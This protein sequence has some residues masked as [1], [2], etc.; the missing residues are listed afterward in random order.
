MIRCEILQGVSVELRH[1][2]EGSGIN[3]RITLGVSLPKD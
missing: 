3:Y 1:L 2:S